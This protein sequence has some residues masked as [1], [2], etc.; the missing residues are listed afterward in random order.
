LCRDAHGNVIGAIGV[1]GAAADEDEHC[2]V[3][4]ARALGEAV[5]TEPATSPLE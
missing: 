1:S 4:G 3:H 2:A 5:L